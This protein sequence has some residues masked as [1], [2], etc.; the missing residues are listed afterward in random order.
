M[1]WLRDGFK[2]SSMKL[3]ILLTSS[4]AF[5][6]S[7]HVQK[8]KSDA[9]EIKLALTS[10]QADCGKFPSNEMG[11]AALLEKPVDLQCEKWHPYLKLLP[12]DG[13]KRPFVY[14][15][16]EGSFVL[17]SLGADGRPEGTKENADIVVRP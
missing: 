6:Q 2:F 1:Q 15:S 3:L 12:T 8:T 7:A 4:L 10:F 16:S 11:L 13:W 9:S 17:T 14:E 5:A